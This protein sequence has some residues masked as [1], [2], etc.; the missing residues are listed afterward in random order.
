MDPQAAIFIRLFSRSYALANNL[1]NLKIFGINEKILKKILNN[2]Q[3]LI[4]SVYGMG[5]IVEKGH[6]KTHIYQ[7]FLHK[8]MNLEGDFIVDSKMFDNIPSFDSIGGN[9]FCRLKFKTYD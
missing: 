2:A 6:L 3:V 1:Y 5:N 9:I 7:R 8:K 4:F